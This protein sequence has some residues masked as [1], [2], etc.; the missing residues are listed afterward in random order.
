M[1]KR[2]ALTLIEVLT[3]LTILVVVLGTYGS[4]ARAKQEILRSFKQSS[5]YQKLADVQLERMLNAIH[6]R[7]TLK[8]EFASTDLASQRGAAATTDTSASRIFS[9]E[10]RTGMLD[11][12]VTGSLPRIPLLQLEVHGNSGEAKQRFLSFPYPEELKYNYAPTGG[13]ATSPANATFHNITD[14]LRANYPAQLPL[15]SEEYLIFQGS[16]SDFATR[17]NEAGWRDNGPMAA[18]DNSLAPPVPL[19]FSDTATGNINSEKIRRYVYYRKIREGNL[20]YGNQ[21]GS[22]EFDGSDG[23]YFVETDLDML[24]IQHLNDW[25]NGNDSSNGGEITGVL[26]KQMPA[27]GAMGA[28]SIYVMVVVRAWLENGTPIPITEAEFQANSSIKAVSTGIAVPTYNMNVVQTKDISL[29]RYDN[30]RI[31]G[32]RMRGI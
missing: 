27:I 18:E 9:F 21:R 7:R 6:R 23:V 15:V 10:G 32:I 12:P 20:V 11:A 13:D 5:V 14:F 28:H 19:F 29:H 26:G 2:R 3:S 25:T 22:V 8:R 17:F 24:F 30:T 1:S 4:T 16:G 31:P